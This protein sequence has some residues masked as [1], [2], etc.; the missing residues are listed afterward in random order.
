MNIIVANHWLKKLG[1]SE[2]YTYALALELRRQGHH[3]RFFTFENGKVSKKLLETGITPYRFGF[4]PDLILANHHTTVSYFRSRY[5]HTKI[6][7]T[8]HGTTP[9]LEQPSAD[10]NF[11]V[12]ISL[13]IE[14]YLRKKYGLESKVIYNGIDCMRF[15]RK[16]PTN[17][18]LKSVLSLSHSYELN[19]KL[20][21]LFNRNNIDFIS[22]NKYK[23]PVWN[24]EDYIN[25]ADMVISI[26]R[27][28]YESMACGRAVLVLDKRPYQGLMG[29]G[30]LTPELV[31]DS[32]SHNCSGRWLKRTDVERMIDEAISHYSLHN[33]TYNR[34]F[35][36]KNLNIEEQAAKYLEIK[37]GINL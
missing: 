32:L 5:P 22:L 25:K 10:A 37:L 1:G 9:K 7:Q 16:N 30:F 18:T 29:D 35:A 21:K 4:L 11:Y 17:R 34:I 3:V 26:G 14:G 6:I 20:S 33:P 31:R 15:A 24:I 27:G 2:C 36:L 8:I 23:N 12:A 19:D 13:E 28:V